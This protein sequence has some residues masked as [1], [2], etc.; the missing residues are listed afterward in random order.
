MSLRM[1]FQRLLCT[2]NK[3]LA[4]SSICNRMLLASHLEVPQFTQS[5][6][7]TEGSKRLPISRKPRPSF[8]LDFC[9]VLFLLLEIT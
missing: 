9:F 7:L 1:A 4:F 3:A 6:K 5:Y 2:V 8:L